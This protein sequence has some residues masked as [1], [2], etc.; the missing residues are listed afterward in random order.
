M[1]NYRPNRRFVYFANETACI[2]ITTIP[3]LALYATLNL[4]ELKD[5]VCLWCLKSHPQSTF[6]KKAHTIPKSLGG[7]N[8]NNNVC[9]TC[10]EFFGNKQERNYSIEEAL[11]E[12]FNISRNRFLSGQKPKKQVGKF[13]SRF[14]DIKTRN[15]KPRLSIKSAFRFDSEFQ[16][17]LCRDFKRGLYKMYLEEHNRQ[18]DLGYEEHY[19]AIRD[20]ARFDKF[21]MPIFY[22][23]RAVGLFPM[24]GREAETPVLIFDRMLYLYSNDKFVEIEFLGHV[25]GFP[26]TNVSSDEINNYLN[27][28]VKTKKKHFSKFTLIEKLTDIDLALSILETPNN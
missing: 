20:F 2:L 1:K 10:N 24:F 21:D 4:Y 5:R 12:A 17:L 27:E 13:R 6:N 7:Q 11:K 19:N 18:T 28:S 22:F 16:K 15:N 25:F 8:Y 26:I 23:V 14:F 9:D 3:I